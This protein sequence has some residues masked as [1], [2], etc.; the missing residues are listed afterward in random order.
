VQNVRVKLGRFSCIESMDQGNPESE[1]NRK[2]KRL[3]DRS[4]NDMK[5]LR[6]V[7]RE[8]SSTAS[9]APEIWSDK[10]NVHEYVYAERLKCRKGHTTVFQCLSFG[11]VGGH[12]HEEG[13]EAKKDRKQQHRPVQLTPER[14]SA[15]RA[16]LNGR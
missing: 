16:R 12:S 1:W 6:V 9:E 13:T 14:A 5:Q 4:S 11:S 3:Y 2:L 10:L 7:V 8:M 15:K